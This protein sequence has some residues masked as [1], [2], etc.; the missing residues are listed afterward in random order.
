[1]AGCSAGLQGHLHQPVQGSRHLR[2]ELI[3]V[4]CD[5]MNLGGGGREEGGGGR[6]EEGGRRKGR[7][8]TER[9]CI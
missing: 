4:S 7:R 5:E 3:N 8:G 6:E 2:Y 1:M 9:E